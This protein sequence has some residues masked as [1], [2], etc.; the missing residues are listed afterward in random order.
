MKRSPLLLAGLLLLAACS[1]S[2]GD[3]AHKVA[4][5]TELPINELMAHVVDPAAEAFWSGSG[6]EITQNG[7]VDRAPTTEEGWKHLEDG[8]AGVVEA[9][10]LLQLAGRP[11][12]PHNKWN[13]H[14]RTLSALGVQAKDAAEAHDRAAMLEIGIK[15]DQE[16]D[17]C[18]ADFRP[19]ATG[20]TS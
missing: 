18:H 12:E 7:E 14:A 19:I 6:S 20:P 4:S 8:A 16:C 3:A 2:P 5:F 11:R 10:N 15:L 17:A 9:G 13:A 1:K